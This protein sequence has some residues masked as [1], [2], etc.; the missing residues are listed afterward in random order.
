MAWG[1][2]AVAGALA[3]GA[4]WLEEWRPPSP[5]RLTL[6]VFRVTTGA[7]NGPGSLRDAILAADRTTG[8]ARV[9][10]GVPRILVETPLPPLVNPYGIVL[11]AEPAGAELEASQVPGAVLDVAAAGSFVSD[12]RIQGGRAGVV[13][14]ARGVTLRN[15]H[16][17]GTDTAVLIGDGADGATI[18]GT[19]F[20]RNRIGVQ[21]AGSTGKATVRNNRFE[22]HGTAAVWAVAPQAPDSTLGTEVAIVGNRFQNDA[23]GVVAVN[24]AARVE[25]NVFDDQRGAAVHAS[26][27]RVA[28][29]G[30]RIRGGRGFGIYA[31]GVPSGFMSG[32]EIARNCSGGILLRHVGNTRVIGNQIYQNGYGL[33]I[34]QSPAQSPNTVADNLIA[35]HMGDGIVLIAASPILSRNRLLQNRLAGL[36]LSSMIAGRA[37]DLAAA[38]LLTANIFQGNGHDDPQHD[39]YDPNTGATAPSQGLA[40]CPW[41]LG[42]SVVYATQVGTAR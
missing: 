5:D 16:V 42:T 9:V 10:V 31:E 39:E 33:V 19:A 22:D 4:R 23:A 35:D 34:M 7:D 24:V 37:T 28:L 27:A 32:N 38:P 3:V 21:I 14:R 20:V 15:L 29:E 41:R 36:R 11:E 17:A 18:V 6:L 2:V 13:I 30:N 8:R 1:A 40:D 12:L 25:R 26:G